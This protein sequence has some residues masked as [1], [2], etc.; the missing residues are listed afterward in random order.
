MVYLPRFPQLVRLRLEDEEEEEDELQQAV[1]L[2]EI[3]RMADLSCWSGTVG[4][5]S[6]GS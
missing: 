5:D 1:L 3:E 2:A 4:L 6:R